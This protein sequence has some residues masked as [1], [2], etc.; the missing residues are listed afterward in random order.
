ME[1][2]EQR[3]SELEELL[4]EKAVAVEQLVQ[5]ARAPPV[6]AQRPPSVVPDLASLQARPFSTIAPDDTFFQ[7]RVQVLF[8]RPFPLALF[9]AFHLDSSFL[10]HSG[11]NLF[12]IKRFHFFAKPLI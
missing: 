3:A 1:E 9:V 6:A 2:F 10:A 11:F 8:L 4:N 5:Q 12:L 7:S